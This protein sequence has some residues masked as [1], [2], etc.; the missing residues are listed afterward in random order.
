MLF[1]DGCRASSS[2]AGTGS[3]ASLC[4]AG[5]L[6][7]GALTMT[8]AWSSPAAEWIGPAAFNQ[9][10]NLGSELQNHGVIATMPLY[11]RACQCVRMTRAKTSAVYAEPRASPSRWP[12]GLVAGSR[13]SHRC[14]AE[15]GNARMD[16]SSIPSSVSRVKLCD[17]WLSRCVKFLLPADSLPQSGLPHQVCLTASS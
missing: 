10:Y 13:G 14:R 9:S 7:C 8:C 6:T 3:R 15:T 5:F 16:C 12:T 17:W 4:T 11:W 1:V 2:A